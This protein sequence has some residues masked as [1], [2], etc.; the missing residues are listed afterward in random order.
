MNI[1]GIGVCGGGEAER[2]M[3]RTLQEFNRLCD[4]TLIATCNATEKEK[5]LLDKYNI[6]HYEDNREWGKFQPDIKTTLLKEVGEL[7]PDWIIAL[8]MDEVFAPEFD[9]REAERLAQA[10][11]YAYYFMI[12]NLYNDPEHF[13]HSAGIQ[14]FWNIRFYKYMP[15]YGLEFQKKNL[16]CGLGPPF[17]YRYGWY[18]PYYVEHYGLMKKDDRIA[19]AHRYALYDPTA[20]FKDKVYYDELL[21]ELKSF[22]FDRKG[23]L[24]KLRSLQD[25]Q[26]RKTPKI[27]SMENKTFYYVERIKDGVSLGTVDIPESDLEGTLLNNPEWKVLSKV[28]DVS[29]NVIVEEPK[30]RVRKTKKS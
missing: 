19:K 18:A 5:R 25:T 6:L 24:G 13:A 7:K 26:P 15:Q 21:V 22:P 9:R 20:K 27:T 2:Y 3:E 4:K 29:G 12:V 14:R 16:H 28:G 23:L 30:K 10:G 11:E 1:V 8:D 17:V